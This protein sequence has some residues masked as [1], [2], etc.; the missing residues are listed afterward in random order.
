MPGQNLLA[1]HSGEL[2][3]EQGLEGLRVH[4][5]NTAEQEHLC[6]G[7]DKPASTRAIL[8]SAE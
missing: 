4:H 6:E 1:G 8:V 5:P 2:A 3:P 7:I